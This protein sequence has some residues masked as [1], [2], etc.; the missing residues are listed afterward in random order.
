MNH[1]NTKEEYGRKGKYILEKLKEYT[2]DDGKL[3]ELVMSEELLL[4]VLGCL[5]WDVIPLKRVP[6]QFK[7]YGDPLSDDADIFQQIKELEEVI[8]LLATFFNRK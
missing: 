2:S 7:E 4:K 1:Q 8:E 3:Y 5:R 6:D